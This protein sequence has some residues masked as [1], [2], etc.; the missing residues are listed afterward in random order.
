MICPIDL[1]I[2]STA[3]GSVRPFFP[4]HIAWDEASSGGT[5]KAFASCK[6]RMGFFA[7]F[8]CVFVGISGGTVYHLDICGMATNDWNE[9]DEVHNVLDNL[10]K[11][12]S[13]AETN[14]MPNWS[15]NVLNKLFPSLGLTFFCK[16][17][18]AMSVRVT[19]YSYKKCEPFFIGWKLHLVH[20]NIP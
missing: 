19:A 20:S 18:M 2:P 10:F 7:H 11:H 16:N 12:T 6:V 8:W 14:S 13:T 5:A 3:Q 4:Q 15:W 17:W 1:E 9:T